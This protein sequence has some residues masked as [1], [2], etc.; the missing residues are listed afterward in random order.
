MVKKWS[1]NWSKIGYEWSKFEQKIGQKL[2]YFR[3]NELAIAS[4]E[5]NTLITLSKQWDINQRNGR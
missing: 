5:M 3:V 4:R 2:V 1:K